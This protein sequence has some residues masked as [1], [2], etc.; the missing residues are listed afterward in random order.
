MAEKPSVKQILDVYYALR[1]SGVQRLPKPVQRSSA[2]QR[3]SGA[4]LFLFDFMSGNSQPPDAVPPIL[5]RL[6]ER[7]PWGSSVHVLSA[8][9][10]Q[11]KSPDMSAQMESTVT[12]IRGRLET[13]GIRRVVCFGWRAGL[14]LSV[15]VGEP[16]AIPPE[17]F[18]PV[19]C[20]VEGLGQLEFLVLPDVRE[21]E[22]FPE[23]RS[24]V[25]ESLTAFAPASG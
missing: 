13:S 14:A 21:L 7:L 2:A 17:V 6:L 18:E 1:A 15:A 9:A 3:H 4:T 8:F 10:V 5:G 25:W 24:K 11:P 19:P 12:I 20:E 22:A 23:W 16:Y